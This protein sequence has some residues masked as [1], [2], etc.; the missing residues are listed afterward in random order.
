M[1]LLLGLKLTINSVHTLRR[2]LGPFW[3]SFADILWSSRAPK[4]CVTRGNQAS[5]GVLA[6]FYF[7]WL[8]EHVLGR[9]RAKK[10]TGLAHKLQLLK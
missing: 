3:G 1:W 5:F 9:F 8:F 6:T 2:I 7:Y 10:D 4:G